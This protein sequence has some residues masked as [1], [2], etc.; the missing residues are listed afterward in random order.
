VGFNALVKQRD[1]CINVGGGYVEKERNVSSRL[2]YHK[3]YVLYPFVTY[4]LTPS[5]LVRK[6]CEHRFHYD[7]LMYTDE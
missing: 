7:E 5:Y 4:L 1:K 6:I 3:F 2:E